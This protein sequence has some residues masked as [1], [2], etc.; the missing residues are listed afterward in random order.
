MAYKNLGHLEQ[1]ELREAWADEAG[2]FTPW[3]AEPEHLALLGKTIGIELEVEAQEKSVGPFRADILCKEISTDEDRWIL[4]ENQL[5]RTNHTH[6]GQILT[7]AAGLNA[8]TIVWVAQRFTEEHRATLDWLNEI[9][10]ER[11]NFFGLEIELWRID[12][13]P[14]APKF[15]IVSKPNEWSRS[16]KTAAGRTKPGAL[17]EIQK[18][19]LDYWT[20]FRRYMEANSDIPCQKARPQGWIIHSIGR[21]GF[22]LGSIA[23]SWNNET[24]SWGGENRVQ[25]VIRGTDLRLHF[26]QFKKHK[27]V[28][29]TEFGGKLSWDDSAE[30]TC[31]VYVRQTADITDRDDWP[32]QHEWLRENVEA[33]YRVFA[34]RVR[35]LETTTS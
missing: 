6:L 13:S 26:N 3:L 20:E 32:K 22:H 34:P 28:I 33:L 9:T 1:V 19:Q 8:V 23:S 18:L 7:Y 30:K 24:H 16:I 17:S 5:E 2:D 12:D 15:N 29:E 10:D 4:I 35:N 21:S 27:D 31:R 25:F 11:F 14:F